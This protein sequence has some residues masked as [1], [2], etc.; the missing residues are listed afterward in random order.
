M[1]RYT[2]VESTPNGVENVNR[3]EDLERHHPSSAE[4][5]S[6]E[7]N[8][9]GG[10]REEVKLRDREEIVKDFVLLQNG[11]DRNVSVPSPFPTSYA[12]PTGDPTNTVFFYDKPFGTPGAQ[13]LGAVL[14]ME[15]GSEP[16]EGQ[17]IEYGQPIGIQSDHGSRGAIHVHL[18][19]DLPTLRQYI[20]DVAEGRIQ[21]G[22]VVTA[23][24]PA[25]TAA[26]SPDSGTV[27]DKLIEK[28]EDGPGVKRLQEA[29]NSAGIQVDGK[30]LPTTGY[31]GDMTEEAVKQYQQQ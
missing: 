13:R 23:T 27:Q 3:Y 17:R 5:S 19:A 21:S 15:P 11:S 16:K 29:L 8:T 1:A 12:H 2:I 6:R 7:Y 14:H 9:I 24:P 18:Q 26:S 30:P 10:R 25:G 22:G 28:G 4:S 31:Y 20:S